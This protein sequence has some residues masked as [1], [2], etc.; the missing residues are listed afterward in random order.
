MIKSKKLVKTI[1]ND[2]CIT[3]CIPPLTTYLHPLTLELI[4][5]NNNTCATYQISKK[6]NEEEK[7]NENVCKLKDNDDNIFYNE[8]ELILS[9]YN[10]NNEDF[11]LNVYNIKSFDDVIK[12]SEENNYIVNNTFKRINKCA[13]SAYGLKQE[14]ITLQVIKYYYIFFIKNWM[15]TFMEKIKNDYEFQIL[16]DS[17]DVKMMIVD[18]YIS[19][20]DFDKIITSFINEYRDKWDII[21][22]HFALLNNY[23][24]QKIISKLKQKKI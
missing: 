13:W 23:I 18:N 6:E 11:L 12:W 3:K 19:L 5:I 24:Y 15:N 17:E 21:N 10:L 7:N 4:N 20:D 14:I 9:P 16:N 2:T 22:D 1:H 8:K